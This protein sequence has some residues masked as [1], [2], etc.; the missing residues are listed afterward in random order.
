MRLYA[1]TFTCQTPA[2]VAEVAVVVLF[3]GVALM[4]TQFALAKGTVS[5]SAEASN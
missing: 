4:A 3:D 5:G 1:A 2:D